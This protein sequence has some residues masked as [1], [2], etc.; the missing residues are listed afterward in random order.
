MIQQNRQKKKNSSK[1]LAKGP[2][3]YIVSDE[4]LNKGTYMQTTSQKRSKLTS[5]QLKCLHAFWDLKLKQGK[6]ARIDYHGQVG[7]TV[8]NPNGAKEF[9]SLNAI[10]DPINRLV[11]APISQVNN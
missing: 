10:M 1:V 4:Q 9:Y 7:V 8:N 11:L 5:F 2:D 6:L 3:K